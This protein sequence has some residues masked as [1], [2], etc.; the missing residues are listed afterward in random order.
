[1]IPSRPIN[2]WPLFPPIVLT[3]LVAIFAMAPLAFGQPSIFG[4]PESGQSESGQ[5]ET[6][7]K[8]AQ[9]MSPTAHPD[10]SGVWLERDMAVTFS[11]KEPPFK[12]WARA[13]FNSVKPGYGPHA[14]SDPQD[15]ILNCLPPG[16]PRIM[17]IPFPM[18]IVQ[19]PGQ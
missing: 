8:P 13:K 19:V 12:P 6:K 17:L 11:A 16:V 14:T 18:Q 1:M 2:R 9:P 7:T 15:P 10:L 5:S 4:Q 3:I